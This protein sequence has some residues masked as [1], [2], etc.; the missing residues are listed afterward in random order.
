MGVLGKSLC[1][2]R[3]P[4]CRLDGC[5]REAIASRKGALLSGTVG[6]FRYVT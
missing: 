5:F 1:L 3:V 2:E 6:C 4:Y